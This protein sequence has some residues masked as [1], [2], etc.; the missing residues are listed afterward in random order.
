M[1]N[2]LGLLKS[3]PMIGWI[4]AGVVALIGVKVVINKKGIGGSSSGISVDS[5]L[6]NL[7]NNRGRTERAADNN[8]DAT[9]SVNNARNRIDESKRIV[10]NAEDTVDS[11][12][13]RLDESQRVNESAQST[14]NSLS[15]GLGTNKKLLS[16]AIN[17]IKRVRSRKSTD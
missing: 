14:V 11:A 2:I 17:I 4:I 9:E 8:R 15:G 10:D 13:E 3:I 16:N 6:G 12:K 7:R 5:I 1:D